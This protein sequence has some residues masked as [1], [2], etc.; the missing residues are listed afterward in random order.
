[1][2]ND[3]REWRAEIDAL[4]GELL[5]ILAK[6]MK[7]VQ[8]IGTLKKK[9]NIPL[10]D[11]KRWREVLKVTVSQAKALKLSKKFITDLY[12]LIHNHALRIEEDSK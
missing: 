12:T 1:M 11:T 2:K 3:L 9:N 4:D 7:I 10:L 8:K 6:R 5:T